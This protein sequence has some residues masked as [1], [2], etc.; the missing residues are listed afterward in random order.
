MA[1]R[2]DC[3]RHGEQ[4]KKRHKHPLEE[5]ALVRFSKTMK[6]K[7]QE[8]KERNWDLSKCFPLLFKQLGDDPS[9]EHVQVFRLDAVQDEDDGGTPI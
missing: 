9:F 7:S 8:E 1:P 2:V 6:S 5:N 4:V 3:D